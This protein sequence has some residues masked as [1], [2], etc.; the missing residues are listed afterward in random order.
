MLFHSKKSGKTIEKLEL[1]IGGEEIETVETFKYLGVWLNSKMTWNNHYDNVSSK[2]SSRISLLHRRK[3]HFRHTDMIMFCNSLVLS[4]ID[5]CLP[6]WSGICDSKIDKLDRKIV[7]MIGTVLYMKIPK[8]RNVFDK[9]E[10]LNWL[11]V[12]ER[13]ILYTSEYIFKHIIQ[14]TSLSNTLS[15]LFLK[16]PQGRSRRKPKDFQLPRTQ[17]KWAQSN[18]QYRSIRIWNSITDPI[19]NCYSLKHFSENLRKFVIESRKE[20]FLFN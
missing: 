19:Q 18:F 15:P 20:Q 11:I 10:V 6:I 9:Y 14:K 1:R 13:N 16:L 2:V 8:R 12:R 3:R 7:H 4:L 5:Y 17:T